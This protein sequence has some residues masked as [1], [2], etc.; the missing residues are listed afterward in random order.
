MNEI[1]FIVKDS[2]EGGYQASGLKDSIYTEGDT[3]EAL[4]ANVRE[5]VRCHFEDWKDKI[6][7]LH[8]VRQEVFSA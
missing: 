6:I 8:V 7:R 3:M 4:R 5:A 2:N 1:I